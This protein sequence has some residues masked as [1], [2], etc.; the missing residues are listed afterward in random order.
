MSFSTINSDLSLKHYAFPSIEQFRNV[1][2]NVNRAY[3]YVGQNVT[4]EPIYDPAIRKPV[5]KFVGTTKLHGTN[6]G[7]IIDI[8]NEMVYYQSRENIISPFKD[9]AGSASYIASMQT[10]FVD[11]I[12][13][14]LNIVNITQK[15]DKIAVYGEW[16]GGSIQKG[17]AL[18][19]LEK[20]FVIFGIRLIDTETDGK[21]WLNHSQ[22]K[23][24]RV[25]GKKVYNILDY[26]TWEIEIDFENPQLAQNDLV[27]ITEEIERQCPVAK[28]FGAE[29][30]GEGAVYT[31]VTPPYNNNSGFWMKVKGEKHQSSKVKTL[32][33]VDVE[34]LNS[35]NEM[36]DSF[37][38]ESRCKQ[39]IDKL[40]EAGLPLTRAS[41]GEYIRW[42]VND[43][44]KEEIDTI[45]A[46]G[47]EVKNLGKP[48]SDR[49][50]TWFFK[51]EM[52]F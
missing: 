33:S 46:N 49:A 26:P 45:L 50:R 21:F 38:T 35:I 47:F 24:F 20:M 2:G 39:S 10:E 16:C 32:A 37:V 13:A 22:L 12:L 6:F 27:T 51:N 5:L 43:I 7:I 28:A 11:S 9:N 41:L 25:E 29:G 23:H 30:I 17:V 52:N 48:I 3:N 34:K 36:L 15:Y 14:S 8:P 42:I 40:K 44:A 19:Q 31:C 18:N 1:I 4:D